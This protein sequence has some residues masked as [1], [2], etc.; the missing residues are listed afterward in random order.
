ML[1]ILQKSVPNLGDVGDVVK[2]KDGFG[3]N[4][5]VPRGFAV[6]A[7][8]KNTRRMEHQKRVVEATKAKA[9]SEAEALGSKLSGTAVTITA[10]VGDEGKI[11]GS[12][13]NR[14]IAEMLAAEG[15][16]VDR[17]TIDIGDA[18]KTTG[19]YD[20]KVKLGM[21]VEATVKVFVTEG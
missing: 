7:D 2:V 14:D 9:L 10:K 8:T 3:R 4:Y 19:A 11:F 5:L 18:I 12:V 16:E 20:V 17:K 6:I 1:V 21:G 15:I 13:T